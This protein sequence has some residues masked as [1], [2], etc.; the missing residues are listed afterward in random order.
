MVSLFRKAVFLYNSLEVQDKK[1]A[2]E[3]L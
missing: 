2:D 3:I 1:V